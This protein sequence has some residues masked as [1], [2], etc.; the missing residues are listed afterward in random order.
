MG[1]TTLSSLI[2]VVQKALDVAREG[3]TCLVVAHRLSTVQNA[4][5]VVVLN[6]GKVSEQGNCYAI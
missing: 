2:Q 5:Q 1:H 6:E 3:R 4:D